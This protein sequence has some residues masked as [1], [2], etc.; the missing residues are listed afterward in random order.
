MWGFITMRRSCTCNI[1]VTYGGIRVQCGI[2][3]TRH[4]RHLKECDI[5]T[6]D[7]MARD[8]VASDITPPHRLLTLWTTLAKAQTSYILVLKVC[9]NGPKVIGDTIY[10][11]SPQTTNSSS[12][13]NV[14]SFIGTLET[15]E[16]LESNADDR[17]VSSTN[18]ERIIVVSSS[19]VAVGPPLPVLRRSAFWADIYWCI[20]ESLCVAILS[21]NWKIHNFLQ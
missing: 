18:G 5:M 12:V 20:E 14:S 7:V 11:K 9:W 21:A 1:N 4:C 17:S 2:S 3:I 13:K 8:I 19:R 15:N 6:I 16:D 10:N